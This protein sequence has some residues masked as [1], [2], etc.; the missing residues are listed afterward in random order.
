MMIRR[1]TY[2][3]G[4]MKRSKLVVAVRENSNAEWIN[5][6]PPGLLTFPL[7]I[8]KTNK[9]MLVVKRWH[10]SRFDTCNAQEGIRQQSPTHEIDISVTVRRLGN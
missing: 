1:C 2:R 9:T 10:Q 8:R 3:P 6:A 4:K 5:N 7:S